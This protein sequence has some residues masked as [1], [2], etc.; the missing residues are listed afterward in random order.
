MEE[1]EGAL[2]I[3]LEL[4][5]LPT[6]TGTSFKISSP[7][8]GHSNKDNNSVSYSDID[9]GQGRKFATNWDFIPTLKQTVPYCNQRQ[10]LGLPC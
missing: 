1:K 10:Q 8:G 5:D 9:V 3:D 4:D 2:L 6:S 7:K